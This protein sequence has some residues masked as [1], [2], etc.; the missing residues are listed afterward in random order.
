MSTATVDPHVEARRLRSE[1]E[2]LQVIADQLG[3]DVASAYRWTRGVEV[4]TT[5]R[6]CRTCRGRF[7][8]PRSSGVAVCGPCREAKDAAVAAAKASVAERR[9]AREAERRERKARG[10]AAAAQRDAK[11]RAMRCDGCGHQLL[12]PAPLC[13]FCDPD[14]D[15]QAA[16]A[17]L[18]EAHEHHNASRAVEVQ[19]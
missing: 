8:A 10:A 12:R 1:G 14:F 5:S 9:A 19:P 2:T 15:G 13:G 16:L 11:R 4:V 6:R 7:A 17:A 18:D 3:V